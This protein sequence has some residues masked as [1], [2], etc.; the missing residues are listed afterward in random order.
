VKIVA[1]EAEV[2]YLAEREKGLAEALLAREESEEPDLLRAEERMRQEEG[3]LSEFAPSSSISPIS[4][5][6]QTALYLFIFILFSVTR[7]YV[8]LK[9]FCAAMKSAL[10]KWRLWLTRWR[11]KKLLSPKGFLFCITF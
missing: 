9:N 10:P 5:P 1:E 8:R 6:L 7:C 11:R 2:S 4:F 3:H